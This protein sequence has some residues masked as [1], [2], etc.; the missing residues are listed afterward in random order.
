MRP[1]SWAARDEIVAAGLA[2]QADVER[3]EEA[4]DRLDAAE[5]R[6]WLFPATFVAIGRRA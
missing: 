2:T 3:W 6:P 4:F 1:P 5:R